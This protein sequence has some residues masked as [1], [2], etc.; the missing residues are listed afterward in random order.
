MAKKN[1]IKYY[2]L[3]KILEYEADYNII[4][5]ERSNGKTYSVLDYAIKNYL[6]SGKQLGII[7]RFRED[8]IGKRGNDLFTPLEKN[9][10][11]T[12]YS[13]GEWTHIY[14]YSSRWFMCR[15]EENETGNV[16]RIIDD[17]PFAY[18]FALGSWEHDK[19]TGYPDINT[20]L[21]D[22]F[23][24]RGAYLADEF[25]L[26]MNT[27]STIIR[28]R[29]DVKIFMLANTVNK[30]CPY[31]KEMGL[32]HISQME[33]GTI[34]LY[35][36]GSEKAKSGFLKIAVEY[37]DTYNKNS[38]PSNKYFAFDNAKLKMI[39]KGS[40]EIDIYPHCPYKYKPKDI[41]FTYFI[42]FDSSMLQ[43]EIVSLDNMMFTFIHEKTTPLKDEK[44]DLIYST[45][46]NPLP[47]WRRKI[48]KPSLDIEKKIAKFYFEDKVFY[49]DNEVG[50]IVRNYLIWCGKKL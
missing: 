32:K 44:N 19:G 45:R 29:D 35:S 48:T 7:R 50:E 28:L 12:K 38:K 31:F 33:Q 21:F 40:W 3:K 1:S 2:S 8:F 49:Q 42:E 14:Y 20:I 46:Y 26:F 22:E 9:D 10:L 27:L 18:A 37:C 15:Y 5:G 24:T 43:C 25:V 13:D 11:I 36:I 34:D 41:I 30:Y 4:F 16:N 39:T 23:I 6:E 17:K 47:N